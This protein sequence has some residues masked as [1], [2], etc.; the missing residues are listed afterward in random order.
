MKSFVQF[1][2]EATQS[3]AAMQAKKLGLRGDGHGGWVDR[4]GKVVART[5]DG[6]L[7][8]TQQRKSS[9]KEEPTTAEPK[10]QDALIQPQSQAAQIPPPEVPAQQVSPEEQPQQEPLPTLTVVFGRF[11]PPTVGH[12]KLLKAADRASAGGDLKIY[13]SRSQDPKKNPLDPDTKI[14][15]MR[16]MFPEYGERIIND[17]KMKTIF[18][19]LVTANEEGYGNVNI[20]VG[21][22]RQ[23]EFDNLAQ[24]Y[25]GELY[26]FDLINVISAGVRDADSEGVEGMSASKMRKAVMDDDYQS[27][28]R[29]TPKTLDD[30]DT[31]ALFNLVRQGMGVK[32]AKVKKEN[33]N[34]WEISPKS[35]MKNLREN[36]IKGKIFRLGDKVQ[37]LNTGLIG[38]VIR[39]GTNHLICVSEEGYMFKSWI[40][41]LMEY[42]EVKMERKTRVPGKPNTLVGT[43]GYFKYAVDMT[44]GFN[45]GDKTNLQFG[46]KPYRGYKQI[47][48]LI[49]KY[50]AK[51]ASTY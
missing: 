9:G 14:S 26:N 25:N 29:G 17:Y 28:R 48:E 35:D 50:K 2:S 27:F 19:V 11:N 31:Q 5:E 33:Y 23:S 44:P 16:K 3:Q 21:S 37:N 30:A 45:P 15:Y 39:R 8:F 6:K 47:K 40:R 12:E 43:G 24:K 20:V 32:K 10:Q 49:N 42:N 34:L 36:Y 51:K 4:S 7:K 1:L 22:D 18:D 38:E 46:A 13:P 41:D